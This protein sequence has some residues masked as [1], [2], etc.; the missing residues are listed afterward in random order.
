MKETAIVNH[1]RVKFSHGDVRLWRNNVGVLRDRTGAFVTYGLCPGSSDLIG[2]KSVTV[3]QD[4]V[5]TRIAIFCALEGKR[6]A[7]SK[8]TKLQQQF[9]DVVRQAGGISGTFLCADDAAT[10][11]KGDS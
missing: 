9:I 8:P 3:T 2:Y 7:R 5:G 6:D 11:L 4:M 1:V 10:I